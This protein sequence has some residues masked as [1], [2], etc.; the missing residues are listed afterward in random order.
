MAPIATT[1]TVVESATGRIGQ[2]KLNA[3]SP[4]PAPAPAP[5]LAPVQQ[6]KEN[7]RVVDPFNYVV[8][9]LCLSCPSSLWRELTNVSRERRTVMDRAA[10]TSMPIS[11]VSPLPCPCP[12]VQLA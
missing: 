7:V 6:K 2:L 1:D 4:A 10:T 9:S 3:V 12:P 8:S 5:V 11:C